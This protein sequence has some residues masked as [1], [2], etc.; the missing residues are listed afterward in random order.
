LSLYQ[1][2][3]TLPSAVALKSPSRCTTTGTSFYKDVTDCWLPEWAPASGGKEVYVVVNGT[4]WRTRA[5]AA[6]GGS[7]AGAGINPFLTSLTTSAYPGTCTNQ[8][9]ATDAGADFTLNT[10]PVTL[11][12]SATTSVTGYKLTPNDCGGMAVVQI[13]AAKFIPSQ[14]RH[15]H[16]AA[17]GI[18]E[19]WETL[20]AAAGSRG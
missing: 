3:N 12:T 5:G 14:R 10:T 19:V 15:R 1:L 7:R 18:P 11:P 9:S 20:T 4:I 13:G 8:G 2:D 16:V 6:G 17:N